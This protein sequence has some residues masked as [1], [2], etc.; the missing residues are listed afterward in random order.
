MLKRRLIPALFLKEG[1]MVRSENFSTHQFI[2]NPSVHVQRMV[3]W[4]V[5]E[6]LVV[7]INRTKTDNFM[8][9][10]MDYPQTQV[11]DLFSFINSVASECR[12]PLTFGGQLRTAEEIRHVILNGADKV[13]VNTM[14][15]DKPKDIEKSVKTLGSQAIVAGIDYKV[16][17]GKAFVVRDNGQNMTKI[18]VK[19]WARKAEEIGAG[20]IFLHAIDRDGKAC[21]YDLDNIAETVNDI[22]I[23]VIACGG[24]GHQRD[25]LDCFLE[26][27]SS[28]VA[29]GNIFHFTENSYPRAKKYLKEKGVNVR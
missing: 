17:D 11:T 15:F 14:L 19:E 26:T 27:N 6:L 1:W 25:F 28:G 10:R 24:A 3:E 4:D 23:P 7:N 18:S 12:I 21:G 5:D 20:E 13:L 22:S 9:N 16:E 29:A 2:G 8:H